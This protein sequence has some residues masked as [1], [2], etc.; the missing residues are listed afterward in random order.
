MYIKSIGYIC[1]HITHL[2]PAGTDQLVL[3]LQDR[4]DPE[5]L[6]ELRVGQ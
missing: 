5:A 2:S 6:S 4:F 1:N 3:V